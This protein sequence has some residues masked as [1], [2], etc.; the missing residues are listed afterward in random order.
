MSNL[1]SVLIKTVVLDDAAYREWR[2][3][4]NLFLRGAI[5]IVVV[6]LVAGLV[7]FGKDLTNRVRPINA[8]RIEEEIKESFDESYR[9]N[10]W[11]P[12]WQGMP[13]EVREMVD[14]QIEAIIEMIVDIAQVKTP[15]PRVVSG[16]LEAVG[17]FFSR[18][19]SALAG[20][21]FYGALVL[22]A[23]NLLG[24]SAKLPDFLGTVALYATPGLLGLLGWIPCLGPLLGLVGLVWSVAVYVK[25]VSVVSDLDIGRSLVAVLAPAILLILLGILVAILAFIWLVVVF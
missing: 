6:S 20:W 1:F 3:R 2:D 15:L 4:S 11:N 12:S 8:A 16:S 13:P 10:R 23:V 19:P 17:A 24:G 7:T 22:V 18:A 21:L 5:L 14:E 25:S 9:W